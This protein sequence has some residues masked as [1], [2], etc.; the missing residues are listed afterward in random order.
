MT[1]DLTI[2]AGRVVDT[3]GSLVTVEF[4]PGTL[5]S[6]GSPLFKHDALLEVLSHENPSEVLCALRKGAPPP[7]GTLLETA[8]TLPDPVTP[9]AAPRPEEQFATGHLG[10][11][12]LAPLFWRG[13]LGIYGE[14]A[15]RFVED[16]LDGTDALVITPSPSKGATAMALRDA[17]DTLQRRPHQLVWLQEP[18]SHLE[19][20]LAVDARGR[21]GDTALE[22]FRWSL[23]RL[24]GL[25]T[26]IAN[27]EDR[28]DA[29]NVPQ[30][31]W[32]SVAHV[33]DGELELLRCRTRAPLQDRRRK[34]ISHIQHLLAAAG[35]T[36]DHAAIF[37]FDEL[38]PERAA[39]VHTAQT[40]EA[41]L[42]KRRDV[43]L[44]RLDEYIETIS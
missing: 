13:S 33:F 42:S 19:A 36:T 7:K 26:I 6:P 16:L 21:P 14:G 8:G 27:V 38:D 4:P 17:I 32:T 35:P 25:G 28:P 23:H 11:D 22:V 29:V 39:E 10:L 15:T 9:F 5:P 2:K 44:S 37:G 40:L 18:E 41:Q 43:D 24:M 1:D 12:V 31:V 30:R 3:A 20:W 34:N